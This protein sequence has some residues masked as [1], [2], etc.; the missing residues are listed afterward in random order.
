MYDYVIVGLGN[1]GPRYEWTRHNLGWIAL[2]AFVQSISIAPHWKQM[3]KLQAEILDCTVNGK[4]ILLVKPQTFMNESGQ[5]VQ[6]V[7][8]FYK[9]PHQKLIVLQ[10]DLDIHFKEVKRSFDSGSAGHNGIKSII[11]RLGTKEFT[12]L[13]LGIR[14]S[15]LNKVPTEKFVLLPFSF[16]ERRALKK[17]L[18]DISK[19][20]EALIN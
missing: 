14:S 18:P 5:T 11:D 7:L 12:R 17:W 19:D 9:V 4:R 8:S 6:Q 16:L 13:R 2:D 1:P 15:K 10:D 20:I 3:K